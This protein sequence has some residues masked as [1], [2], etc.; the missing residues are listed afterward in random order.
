[1][2]KQI[3]IETT[4]GQLNFFKWIFKNNVIEYALS[5][6][7]DI[8]SKMIINNTKNKI[9]K[10][11]AMTSNNNDIIKTHCLLYFD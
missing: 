11:K 2:E 5:N 3:T 8:Y 7:D 9:D 1:M 4:V 10:K 6:Y